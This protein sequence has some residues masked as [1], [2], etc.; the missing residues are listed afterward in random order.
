MTSDVCRSV[1][2]VA[3]LVWHLTCAE[4]CYVCGTFSMTSDVCWSVYVCGTFSIFDIWQTQKPITKQPTTHT[5]NKNKNKIQHTHTL[6]S[7][8]LKIKIHDISS[9]CSLDLSGKHTCFFTRRLSYRTCHRTPVWTADTRLFVPTC[10]SSY[11]ADIQR[12][13]DCLGAII[14]LYRATGVLAPT[15]ACYRFVFVCLTYH[16]WLCVPMNLTLI[17]MTVGVWKRHSVRKKLLKQILISL[18]EINKK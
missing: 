14:K 2:C 9:S 6:S 15:G 11:A 7:A 1:L 3:R 5:Q 18:M 16:I 17:V 4:A 12:S 8:A 10:P 13:D